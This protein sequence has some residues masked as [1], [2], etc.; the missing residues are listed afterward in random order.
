MKKLEKNAQ[1]LQS[2]FVNEENISEG[3]NE[4]KRSRWQSEKSLRRFL[5]EHIVCFSGS[6]KGLMVG[7]DQLITNDFVFSRKVTSSS[8][9]NN[10]FQ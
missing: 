7:I 2:H 6:E 10:I 9:R 1:K 5:E 8:G 4:G 3:N